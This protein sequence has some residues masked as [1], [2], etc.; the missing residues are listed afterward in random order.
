MLGAPA[1]GDK[2]VSAVATAASTAFMLHAV[3][4]DLDRSS[5]MM[6]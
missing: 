5:P 4:V 3:G 1:K 2:S 6:P